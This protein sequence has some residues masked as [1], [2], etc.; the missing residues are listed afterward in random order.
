MSICGLFTNWP[1]ILWMG[2]AGEISWPEMK[3]IAGNDNNEL[4][5]LCSISSELLILEIYFT[6]IE[7]SVTLL[8]FVI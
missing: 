4:S 1:G 6:Q 5:R 7:V 3:S 2:F 8:A